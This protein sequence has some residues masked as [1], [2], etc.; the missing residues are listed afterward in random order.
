MNNQER[1]GKN[2]RVHSSLK[3]QVY[4]VLFATAGRR[5]EKHMF[6]K[7]TLEEMKY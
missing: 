4:F 1:L 6:S 3:I 5:S 7:H 2:Q